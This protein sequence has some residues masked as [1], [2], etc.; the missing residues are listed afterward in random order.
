MFPIH[1]NY[2]LKWQWL[3]SS[4][5]C[6]KTYL[7]IYL[8][9]IY[10]F[11]AF[12]LLMFGLA[13]WPHAARVVFTLVRSQFMFEIH[14]QIIAVMPP[15]TQ[16]KPWLCKNPKNVTEITTR[17]QGPSNFCN[18]VSLAWVDLWLQVLVAIEC[19]HVAN[20]PGPTHCKSWSVVLTLVRSQFMFEIHNISD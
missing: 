1:C 2:H 4:S 10:H 8:F 17:A 7:G 14:W 19:V 9:Y 20:M 16:N 18:A 13:I 12:M 5:P 15:Y 6:S 3:T 11:S